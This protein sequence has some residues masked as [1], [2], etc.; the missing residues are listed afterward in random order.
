MKRISYKI[1]S[2]LHV[3]N[4]N[5]YYMNQNAVYI[6]GIGEYSKDQLHNHNIS[7]IRYHSFECLEK[8]NPFDE[9]WD[10]DEF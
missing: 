9:D 5:E 3:I 6:N 2:A 1:T 10:E 8:D 7:P 4:T